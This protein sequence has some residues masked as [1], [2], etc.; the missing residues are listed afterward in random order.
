[1]SIPFETPTPDS[2]SSHAPGGT[3]LGGIMIIPPGILMFM[4]IKF[5]LY[6]LSYSYKIIRS[7]SFSY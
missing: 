6:S 7:L 4:L 3:G 1:M 2:L 5:K